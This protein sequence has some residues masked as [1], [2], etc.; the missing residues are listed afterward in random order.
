MLVEKVEP[1]LAGLG[2]GELFDWFKGYVRY[3]ER[4]EILDVS[5]VVP[6]PK[7]LN[8]AKRSGASYRLLPPDYVQP[9]CSGRDALCYETLN[10][11]WICHPTWASEDGGFVAHKKNQFEE[12]MY[13]CEEERYEFDL[14]IERNKSVIVRLEALAKKMNE[15]SPEEQKMFKLP[16]NQLSGTGGDD[17]LYQGGFGDG[18][19]K[20]IYRQV[21]EKI[22]DGDRAREVIDSLHEYPSVTIPIV[23]KRLK[24]KD[25]EWRRSQREW[26]KAWREIDGKNFYK[27]LD[28]QGITFKT[29]D[30]KVLSSKNLIAEIEAVYRERHLQQRDAMPIGQKLAGAEAND[31]S[32]AAASGKFHLQFS[33][34]DRSILNNV[35][36]LTMAYL[37]KGSQLSA[38]DLDRVQRFLSK[39]L[40]EFMSSK[41]H[42]KLTVVP[43][44]DA[45]AVPGSG[46]GEEGSGE[47]VPEKK[48]ENGDMDVDGVAAAPAEHASTFLDKLNGTSAANGEHQTIKVAAQALDRR[49][50]YA[51]TQYYLFFR[52]LQLAYSRLLKVR[53][54]AKS[55][56]TV[57]VGFSKLGKQK[58]AESLDLLTKREGVPVDVED[59][60]VYKAMLS[61]IEKVFEGYV[62]LAVFEEQARFWF[63]TSAYVIYTV[64]KLFHSLCKQLV[65]IVTESRCIKLWTLYEMEQAAK[66]Q[67]AQT[68]IKDGT[69]RQKADEAVEEDEHLFRIEFNLGLEMVT[70]ELLGD[71]EQSEPGQ[72]GDSEAKWSDYIDNYV[73]LSTTDPTIQ[74]K[75]PV[76]LKRC[77]RKLPQSVPVFVIN[78]LECKICVN[79]YKMFF[80]EHS[81]DSLWYKVPSAS[82]TTN[83]NHQNASMGTADKF[84]KWMDAKTFSTDAAQKKD[85]AMRLQKF[86]VE[87]A[88]LPGSSSTAGVLSGG[89]VSSGKVKFET[90]KDQQLQKYVTTVISG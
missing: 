43:S 5:S 64:D 59:G 31:S 23:L 11:Q 14:W 79:T 42:G 29:V 82:T 70:M 52:Y 4:D 33:F 32:T 77:M 8:D 67:G 74:P 39:V 30:K 35:K 55:I 63:G 83:G 68:S 45:A 87:S 7:E 75:T 73:K 37:E 72:Q 27:S 84:V 6:Q 20:V 24:Q 21:I 56:S 17:E 89:S 66:E 76:F 16:G 90:R 9:P 53:E 10:D 2:N 61:L 19:S 81:E 18:M 86:F 25:E 49:S 58:V 51:N 26:N 36:R 41:K 88:S 78:K 3:N 46:E 38:G 54:T 48:Q 85:A 1:F 12:A 22:Y 65:Q 71:E 47:A 13:R 40:K 44:A 50:M 69:Y 80:V 28:H 34:S 57:A 60:D 15:M 62:D